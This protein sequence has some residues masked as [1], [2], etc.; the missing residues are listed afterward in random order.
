MSE[1]VVTAAVIVIG[2]EVLS[3]RTKDV[4]INFLAK[5]LSQIGVRLRE[6]RVI[7]DDNAAIQSVV[8]ECR[9]RHDYV[10]TTGGIGPT[11]DDIT[12]Q[13]IADLFELPLVL[14]PEAR[15]RLVD[16]YGE[17]H[18]NEAR[19]KMAHVPQGAMLIDN[20]VSAAPGFR[21]ENVFVM[22][23]VPMIVEAM[24]EGVKGELNGGDP[25]LSHT[26]SSF[27]MEGDLAAG[28]GSVQQRFP[29]LSFGS[30]P[31][32]RGG[33]FGVSIVVRSTKQNELDEA[34][35]AVRQLIQGLGGDPIDGERT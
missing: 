2:D 30:Y 15:R 24:F 9:K 16:R 20:P 23:G 33:K 31:Y 4:N 8:D 10:F 3:G 14:D 6:A 32:Y 19:L 7:P 29:N 1:R 25:V 5:G 34:V 18:L 27:V 11:H 35:E 17:G 26:V 13:A 21:V 28:L 22:A 12:A